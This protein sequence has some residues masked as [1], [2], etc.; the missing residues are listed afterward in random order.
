MRE[1][2]VGIKGTGMSHLAGYLAKA[3]DDVCGEDIA[4][5]F[6]TAPL[7]DG[8]DIRPLGS[9]LPEDIDELVASAG[10][11]DREVAAIREARERGI[12]VLSYPQKLAQ[13][14]RD[15]FTLAISGTH[16]K[17]TTCAAASHV[18]SLAGLEA[19]SIYGSRLLDGSSPWHGGDRGLV[20]EA[21]EYRRHFLLY[22][23]DVLVITS[24]AFD[25]PDCYETLD[26]VKAA[27]RDRVVA[28]KRGSLVI[29]H[30]SLKR[31]VKDWQ[32][33][34]P[35]LT[36]VS[37][38]PRGDYSLSRRVDGSYALNSSAQDFKSAE[39]DKA[40]LY[41]L[42]GGLL[43]AAALSCGLS[44]LGWNHLDSEA[45]SLL[46]FLSSFPGLA[47]RG[48]LVADEGG[49]MYIDDYAHHPDEIK[50]ALSNIA[51][52]YGR[53]RLVVLFMPHTASRTKAL[54]PRFVDSLVGCDALFIQDAYA[55]SRN[56]GGSSLELYKALDRRVFRSLY[57]RLGTVV[58]VKDDEMA[59]SV[60]SSFLEDGDILVT[61]G[62]GDNRR[63]IPLIAKRRAERIS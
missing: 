4:E 63:L 55:S 8:I 58:H 15:R 30:D 62:A 28:M 34:R 38:G 40:I 53:H 9:R 1:Y 37:Y 6:Y 24:L 2:L 51:H 19:G 11:L 45:Y 50:V 18:A 48:E 43:G 61:L 32:S 16:G 39:V 35:D 12:P 13:L 59:V 27:F 46:P 26:D 14:S 49:V 56:D 10:F 29:C 23:A 60:L 52:K 20:I 36:F 54:L 7:L 44:G 57:T 21:C 47:A 22:D 5:D 17:S 41:D 33:E 25:H 31:S 42:V 3:G